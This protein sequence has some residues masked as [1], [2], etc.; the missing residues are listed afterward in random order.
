MI[1][2]ASSTIKNVIS[3]VKSSIP[4]S[5]REK[6]TSRVEMISIAAY[7]RAAQRGFSG[8]DPMADWLAAEAEIDALIGNIQNVV[9]H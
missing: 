2:L 1:M 7:Y 3:K 6:R 8:G 5:G 4:L 9:V